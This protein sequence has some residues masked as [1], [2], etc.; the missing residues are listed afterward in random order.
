MKLNSNSISSKL[1]RWFYGTNDLPNNLC[2]YFWKL[3]LAWLVLIPYSLVGLPSIVMELY[4]KDYRYHDVSTGKRIGI[5]ALCY[6]V[7]FFIFCMLSSIGWFFVLPEKDSFYEFAGTIGFFIWGISIVIG[8]IEGF[9]AYK[10]WNYKR[11]IKYDEYGR[12]IYNF[13][14]EEKTY[15]VVEFAKAKYNKYCPKIDWIDKE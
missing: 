12:R 1:Y 8:V 2:P 15:L 5:G 10:E 6:I 3:V 4:D 7:L 9:K 13:H 14:K 11:K